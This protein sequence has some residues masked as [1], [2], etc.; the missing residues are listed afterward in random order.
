MSFI[1]K[2]TMNK[3]YIMI[4]ITCGLLII[5]GVYYCITENGCGSSKSVTSSL[6]DDGVCSNVPK[7]LSSVKPSVAASEAISES[8]IPA[9]DDRL[10]YIHICGAVLNPGVYS[11]KAGARV[12]DVIDLSGGLTKEA[13]GD[14]INQA[15]P[16]TDGQRVYVPTMEEA[17]TLDAAQLVDGE[18]GTSIVKEASG[19]VNINTATV[20]E[21]MTLPGI[22]QSKADSIIKY[23]TA[24]GGFN[25]IEDIKNITG[26]KE[27]VFSRIS[28]YITAE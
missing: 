10:I 8:P 25:N 23:R 2:I 22:G 24:N 13:A 5:A 9:G 3:K 15:E 17:K 20:E 6:M 4:G 16:L 7:E 12:Y 19:L 21:L 26:I 11:L 28:P 18:Q 27:G 14:Y 1:G